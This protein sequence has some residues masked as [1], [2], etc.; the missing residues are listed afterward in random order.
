MAKIFLKSVSVN[1]Q[2]DK[3]KIFDWYGSGEIVAEG[4]FIS[5]DPKDLVHYV[6]LGP[7]AMKVG[8]DFAR[9]PNEFLWRP[10]SEITYI[11]EAI[12]SIIAWP[13]DKIQ[14]R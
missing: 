10:T 13:A 1:T 12:G 5:C 11:E 7:N 8:I 14:M 9:K 3:C 2:G 6:P 4:H